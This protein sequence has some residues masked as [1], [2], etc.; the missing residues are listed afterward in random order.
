MLTQAEKI[1]EFEYEYL[2]I[3]CVGLCPI[4]ELSKHRAEQFAIGVPRRSSIRQF[5]KVHFRETLAAFHRFKRDDGIAKEIDRF[6]R[7]VHIEWPGVMAD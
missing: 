6:G 5:A 3:G 7:A 1:F 4:S 2:E